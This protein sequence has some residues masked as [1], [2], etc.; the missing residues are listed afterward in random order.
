MPIVAL[1]LGTIKSAISKSS[2]L[3]T[4]LDSLTLDVEIVVVVP[5][6]TRLR[7]KDGTAVIVF[8]WLIAQLDRA[9]WLETTIQ[10]GAESLILNPG[11]FVA[12]TISW[13]WHPRAISDSAHDSSEHPYYPMILTNTR[14]HRRLS[15][16]PGQPFRLALK[17]PLPGTKVETAASHRHHHLATHDLPLQVRIGVVPS[18]VRLCWYW[19]MGA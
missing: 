18:P 3:Q 4:T 15:R 13:L 1:V 8:G 19:P 5:E 12:Q 9:A 17:D 2:Q 14:F 10:A 11:L 7:L 16:L 6:L